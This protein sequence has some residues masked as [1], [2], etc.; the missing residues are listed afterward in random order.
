MNSV[1][2]FRKALYLLYIYTFPAYHNIGKFLPKLIKSSLNTRAL[3]I[4]EYQRS[5]SRFRSLNTDQI[6][7]DN[8]ATLDS[9]T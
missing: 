8:F 4:Q 6:V 9:Y 7:I 2:I 5:D 1:N 3:V